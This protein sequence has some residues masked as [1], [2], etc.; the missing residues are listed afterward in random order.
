MNIDRAGIAV[1]LIILM[2][3][4]MIAILSIVKQD[5]STDAIYVTSDLSTINRSVNLT[6]TMLSTGT[7]FITPMTVVVAIV[8]LFAAFLIFRKL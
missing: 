8:F 1:F 5:Q 4:S 3:F 6:D 7:S 2:S